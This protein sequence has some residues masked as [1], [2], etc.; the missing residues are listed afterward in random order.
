MNSIQYTKP[1]NQQVKKVVSFTN[2]GSS[3]FLERLTQAKVLVIGAGYSE[4]ERARL[5]QFDP[6][7]I[8]IGLGET[9]FV[10]DSWLNE[11]W[12]P[13]ENPNFQFTC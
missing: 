12:D 7:Y 9:D 3:E 11:N 2:D 1:F 8:G 10:P 6:N 5:C 13:Q 4:T